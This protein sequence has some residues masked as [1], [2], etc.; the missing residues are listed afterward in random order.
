MSPS[1]LFLLASGVSFLGSLLLLG[2]GWARRSAALA[3]WGAG[4]CLAGSG[5]AVV[6]AAYVI[7]STLLSDFGSALV[8][9]AYS[10]LW[11]GVGALAQVRKP[12][13]WAIPL[14]LLWVPVA[15]I[16]PLPAHETL[17]MIALGPFA[18]SFMLVLAWLAW[19]LP[20]QP[21]A[22]LPLVVLATTHAVFSALRSA[23]LIVN[24]GPAAHAFWLYGTPIEGIFFLFCDAVLIVN[25]VR[26]M[27][28]SALAE[29]AYTDFLTGVLS[30]RRFSQLAEKAIARG[31]CTALILDIDHFKTVNDRFG[32]AAGDA[33]LRELGAICRQ[34]VGKTDLIGRL[35]GDEFAL[36]LTGDA[37]VARSVA[38][39]ISADFART[40]AEMGWPA[41]LSTGLAHNTDAQV[42]LDVL[43]DQADRQLYGAKANRRPM[44][45]AD[46]RVAD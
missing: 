14:G 10:L 24:D 37:D 38:A 16:P 12:R 15:R 32:H 26:S 42:S 22:R 25:L 1:D 13:Y 29:E 46:S 34:D 33:L 39:R 43:I 6:I 20:G 23:A 4:Y 41:S 8:L 44:A 36:L 5:M 35:G 18:A 7:G 11:L 19:C 45:Q 40:C 2:A 31:P 28:E 30:R 9:C 27:Q 3:W 17:R 21:R